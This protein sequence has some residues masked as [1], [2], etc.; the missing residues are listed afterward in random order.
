M[1]TKIIKLTAENVKRLNVVEITPEGNL[2]V[3]SGRNG[4]GKSSVLDSI[5]YALAG[6]GSLPSKPV[7]RGEEKAVVELDLGDLVVKRTFT[8]TGGTTLVVTNKDGVRQTSPQGILD[9]LVGRLSFDP[10]AFAQQ[11]AKERSETLRVLVGLDFTAK[12]AEKQKHYDERTNV[13]R[14]A[15]NIEARLVNLPATYADVPAEEVSTATVLDEQ[16]KASAK[17]AENESARRRASVLDTEAKAA[18]ERVRME[19]DA[20]QQ[21]RDEISRLQE[22][23]TKRKVVL[24]EFVAQ[25]EEMAKQ[26]AAAMAGLSSLVDAD[27]TQFKTRLVTI[28]NTNGKIRQNKQR[29]DLT[30]QLKARTKN[31]DGL[32][33][34]IESIEKSKREAI[35]A[36]KFPVD[37]LSIS[38]TGEVLFNGLPFEQASTAEQLRVSVAIGLALNSKLRILLVRRGSDLDAD[39]LRMVAEMATAADAQVW[40]ERVSEDGQSAVIIEDGYVKGATTE[41]PTPETTTELVP[42]LI[43]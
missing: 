1:S 11:E 32:T 34:K 8:P 23:V 35:G 12:D 27:L 26:S 4:Q 19:T 38:E 28:E 43:P 15:K 3:I 7:K 40:L 24:T 33:K 5:M 41:A 6:A 18:A 36:V 16:S 21:I 13:N 20:I 31:A 30:E 14:E 9:A 17:N 29:A 2:V 37:G 10:L 42:E 22:K 39:S 25:Q